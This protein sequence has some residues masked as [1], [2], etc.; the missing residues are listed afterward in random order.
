LVIANITRVLDG[1]L[2][3]ATAVVD[4]PEG[5]FVGGACSFTAEDAAVRAEGEAAERSTL[6]TE[7]P[8]RVVSTDHAT[9]EG[10]TFLA[11]VDTPTAAAEWVRAVRHA[12]AE[13]VWLPADLVLLRWRGSRELPVQQSSV[14]TAAHPDRAKAMESGARECVERYGVR[15]LWS[16]TTRVAELSDRLASVLPGEVVHALERH[17][18]MPHA[19]LIGATLPAATVV[20]MLASA[21]GRATFGSSCAATVEDGLRHAFCEAVSVRAALA[22]SRRLKR[23][24]AMAADHVDHAVRA[25]VFQDAFLAFLRRLECAEEVNEGRLERVDVLTYL[26]REF[27]AEPAIVDLGPADQAH[28]VKVIVPLPEFFVR[29]D[30]RGYVLAPGYL[31]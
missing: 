22:D 30:H 8:R 29:R 31:E 2:A 24:F 17:G 3:L 19:W 18:L 28:V 9:S 13:T 12:S 21:R 23:N 20:V 16:G 27:H 6:L 25:S 11:A 10:G 7:G 14:G 4:T 26:E 15:R 1:Q 5:P